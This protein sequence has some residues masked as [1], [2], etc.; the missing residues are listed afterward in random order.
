MEF[1]IHNTMAG[2]INALLADDPS[3][4]H[5]QHVYNFAFFVES[6]IQ[7]YFPILFGEYMR[8]YVEQFKEKLP[9]EFET[10]LNG[11]KIHHSDITG[12]IADILQQAIDKMGQEIR[13]KIGI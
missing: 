6:A 10:L 5:E 7:R 12:A 8:K 13:I 3:P 4:R 1:S 2:E 11:E 9:V